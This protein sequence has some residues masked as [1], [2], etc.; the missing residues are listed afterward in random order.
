MTRY[1][2]AALLW[3]LA[4]PGWA[5]D[6]PMAMLRFIDRDVMTW[7]NDARLLGALSD[8]PLTVQ[9]G[10]P[11]QQLLQHHLQGA[12]GRIR[13]L[14]LRDLNGMTIAEYRSGDAVAELVR[15]CL[16][17]HYEAAPWQF[18]IIDAAARSAQSGHVQAVFT[19]TNPSDGRVMGALIVELDEAGF[20]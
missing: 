1:V 16:R 14:S 4:A 18:E 15:N 7:A 12:K 19:L 10:H 20:F 13:A 9:M 17:Q 11:A 8:P 2:M 5:Q 3:M 6:R